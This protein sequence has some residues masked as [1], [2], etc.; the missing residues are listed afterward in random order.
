MHHETYQRDLEPLKTETD[1][2]EDD[3][4]E[5]EE[6]IDVSKEKTE[7]GGDVKGEIDEGQIDEKFIIEK[8]GRFCKPRTF[9][10]SKTA[11]QPPP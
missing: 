5:G 2:E 8:Q 3:I 6:E 11:L 1:E 4:D 10:K 9:C 7:E